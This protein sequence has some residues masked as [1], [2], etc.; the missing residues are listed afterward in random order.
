MLLLFS[1]FTLVAGI[2]FSHRSMEIV[3]I[4]PFVAK[5]CIVHW[6]AIS[7]LR[8]A[9]INF[10][11][12][13]LRDQQRFYACCSTD[14]IRSIVLC[15]MDA[16][17]PCI[18]GVAHHPDFD[19]FPGVAIEYL[20]KEHGCDVDWNALKKQPVWFAEAMYRLKD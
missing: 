19:A 18:E 10:V 5:T 1:A 14:M 7:V 13:P 11:K 8:N 20:V 9:N 3:T 4:E 17:T 2:R 6:H 16:D 12:L 15:N